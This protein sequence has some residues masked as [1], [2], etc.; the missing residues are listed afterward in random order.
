VVVESD[1]RARRLD[2]ASRNVEATDSAEYRE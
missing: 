1:A 2:G